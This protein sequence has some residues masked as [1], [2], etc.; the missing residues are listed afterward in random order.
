MK[1][2]LVLGTI[3]LLIVVTVAI[4]KTPAEGNAHAPVQWFT[5]ELKTFTN[6]VNE[7]KASLAEYTDDTNAIVKVKEA[8]LHCRLQYKRIAFF[9]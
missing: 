7:L 9:L 4:W 1:V 5:R 3:V 8:L 6:K 2:Y